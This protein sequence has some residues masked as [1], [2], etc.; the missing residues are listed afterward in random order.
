[1]GMGTEFVKKIYIREN[2]VYL[3]HI[4]SNFNTSYNY[5][6]NETLTKAYQKDGQKGLDLEFVK[7][8][9][10]G[11]VK[12]E[13]TDP[14]VARFL[15]CLEKGRVI[16]DGVIEALNGNLRQLFLDGDKTLTLPPEQ[17]SEAVIVYH[18]FCRDAMNAVYERIRQFAA[19]LPPERDGGAR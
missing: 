1:M 17:Q 8:L 2:G 18:Q 6:K 7:M 5:G 9:F 13:E 11:N 14:S 3:Y 15:P 4:Y 19:P 16:F 12:I 10:N